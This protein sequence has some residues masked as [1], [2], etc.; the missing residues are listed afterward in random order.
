L[1]DYFARV[2][3][4]IIAGLRTQAADLLAQPLRHE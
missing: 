2:T 4:F 1:D 3:D